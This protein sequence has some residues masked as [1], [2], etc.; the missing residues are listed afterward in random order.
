G[1]PL[2]PRMASLPGP[3]VVVVVY[4]FVLVLSRLLWLAPAVLPVASSLQTDEL[5]PPLDSLEPGSPT[6]S[7]PE[8]AFDWPLS[9]FVCDWASPPFAEASP[10]SDLACAPSPTACE[11]PLV[12]PSATPP[13]P[14]VVVVTC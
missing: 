6:L 1:G 9:S 13:L 2:V 8:I 7:R 14:A 4:V 10:P 5:L 12:P 11:G 3:P